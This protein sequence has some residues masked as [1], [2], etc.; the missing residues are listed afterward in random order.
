MF[1]RNENR[2]EGTFAKNHPF[3]KPPS[4]LPVIIVSGDHDL[5]CSKCYDRKAKM[6]FRTSDYDP[7]YLVRLAT[8]RFVAKSRPEARLREREG[9]GGIQPTSCN[10][11]EFPIPDSGGF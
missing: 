5:K 8:S 7:H 2:N 9:G 6:A 1:P 3:T 4:Y 11:I 10:C